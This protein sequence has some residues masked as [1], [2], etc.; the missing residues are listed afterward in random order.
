[1]KIVKTAINELCRKQGIVVSDLSLKI[2]QE[3]WC[4]LEELNLQQLKRLEYEL[5]KI[6]TKHTNG[7][8]YI[9]KILKLR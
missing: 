7:T 1:M 8:N 6:I 2:N 4:S 5:S 3:I 9:I